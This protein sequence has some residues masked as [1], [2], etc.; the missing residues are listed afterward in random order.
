MKNV[1]EHSGAACAKARDKLLL[2][3]Q[4]WWGGPL[5][6]GNLGL[7]SAEVGGEDGG[8][9]LQQRIKVVRLK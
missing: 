5:R 4:K 1:Q 9:A 8:S 7:V 2:P 3:E 6:T